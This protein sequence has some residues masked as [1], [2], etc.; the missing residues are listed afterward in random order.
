MIVGVVGFLGSGKGTV[1]DLLVAEHKFSKMAFADPLK[2]ATAAIFGWPRNMLE[3][4]TAESRAFREAPDAFWSERF[5][6]EVTPRWALQTLGTEGVRNVLHDSAWVCSFERRRT[7]DNVVVV[8]TRFPN[9]IAKIKEL[10][11]FIVRTVRGDEPEWYETAY[12]ENLSNNSERI[13]L[14]CRKELMSDKYPDIHISEWAWIG[15]KYDYVLDNNG[16]IRDLDANVNYML[17]IFGG[18]GGEAARKVA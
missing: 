5:G 7:A 17:K 14:M 10:G 15:T 12:N 4:D 18:A 6:F 16:S 11:G 2:D 1:G 3:G 8:D 9:E 13:E